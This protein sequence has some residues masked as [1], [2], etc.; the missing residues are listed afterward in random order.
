MRSR[1]NSLIEEIGPKYARH[2]RSFLDVVPEYQPVERVMFAYKLLAE[3]WEESFDS[4]STDCAFAAKELLEQLDIPCDIVNGQLKNYPEGENHC[5]NIVEID[6][7]R[8]H[9][10]TFFLNPDNM[11]L[12]L[13]NNDVDPF[14]VEDQHY[15]FFCV[16]N[17]VI[18]Q[19]HIIGNCEMPVDCEHSLS[20]ELVSDL[21]A[22][23]VLLY[24]RNRWMTKGMMPSPPV[25]IHYKPS[26]KPIPLSFE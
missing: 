25:R 15:T 3:L 13:R 2:G 1:I 17:Q 18:S 12:L 16:S 19:T 11:D 7:Q 26:T 6:G 20:H 23:E 24:V 14:Y 22:M 21:A 10:D 8:F 4:D 9:F 5:W